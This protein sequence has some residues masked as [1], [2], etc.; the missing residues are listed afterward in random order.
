MTL[1]AYMDMPVQSKILMRKCKTCGETKPLLTEFLKCENYRRNDCRTCTGKRNLEWKSQNPEATAF[2]NKK[3]RAKRYGIE[4]TL[5]QSI[6]I[7]IMEATKHCPDC[8]VCIVWRQKS[9]EVK[10]GSGTAQPSSG[11]FDRIDPSLGYVEGNVRCTCMECNARK[12]NSP[13]DEWVGLLKVRVEKG[14]IE[15]V[16]PRLLEFLCEEELRYVIQ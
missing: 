15:E 11:S 8:A 3:A 6:W 7:P 1:E 12:N 9:V 5:D 2:T 16:D 10:N 13:V 4:F 14:I